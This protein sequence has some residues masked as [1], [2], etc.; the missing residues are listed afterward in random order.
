MT[1][2]KIC[3]ITNLDDALSAIDAGADALGFNFYPPSPRYITPENARK[4]V[5]QLPAGI[6]NVGVLVNEQSPE[7]VEN[8][9]SA[10]GVEA[11][12]LHGDE[13]PEFCR[14]LENRF[15]IKVLAIGDDFDPQRALDYNVPAFMVDAIDRE[16]HGGTG[17]IADW[18]AARR[19]RAVVPKLF[20]AG[21]LSSDNVA[22][23]ISTVDPYAVDACSALELTPG[24]KDPKKVVAFIQ[25]V[26]RVKP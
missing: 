23:A 25:A 3:G 24:K 16:A 9:A 22:Q 1:I 13:S 2:V 12:Q 19:I 18:S 17:K 6:L 8:I 15:V 26:R 10:A 7:S 20:L 14:K 11:V 5:D 21:G 4:I